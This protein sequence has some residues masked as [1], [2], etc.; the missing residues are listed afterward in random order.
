MH[1]CGE[2]HGLDGAGGLTW[3][4]RWARSRYSACAVPGGMV[5]LRAGDWD[6]RR[7]QEYE[8]LAREAVAHI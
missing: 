2:V 1:G 8:L 4:P 6:V 3:L 7:L 5:R